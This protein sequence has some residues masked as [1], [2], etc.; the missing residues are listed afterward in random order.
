MA[1]RPALLLAV[2]AA[3]AAPAPARAQ[4]FTG[5]YEWADTA[6]NPVTNFSIAAVGGT[7][8]IRVYL[9]E[10]DTAGTLHSTGLFSAQVRVRFDNP[11]GVANV[12]SASDIIRN[13]QFDQQLGTGVTSAAAILNEQTSNLAG[14][15]SPAADANRIYLGTLHFTGQS[16]GTVTLSAYSSDPNGT[17]LNNGTNIS[18]TIN[19]ATATLVVAPVPEPTTGLLVAAAGLVAAGAARRLRR[20]R[21]AAPSAPDSEAAQFAQP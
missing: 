20:G 12:A 21:T 4:T 9:V 16:Q 15:Q 19:P 5:K 6:G 10:T 14:V 8:D 2:A 1:S 7:T 11:A 3:L 18:S 17:F 13:P